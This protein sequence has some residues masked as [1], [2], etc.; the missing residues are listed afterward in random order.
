MLGESFESELCKA[1]GLILGLRVSDKE[2]RH[3]VRQGQ[4]QAICSV[5]EA[6]IN[7][8]S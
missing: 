2:P 5:D 4:F 3:S 8:A 6:L 7:F 1:A